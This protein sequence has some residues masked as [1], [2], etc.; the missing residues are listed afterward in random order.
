MA[1][2]A[3]HPAF[4]QAVE[5]IH[6]VVYFAPDAKERYG[7]LGLRGY[8]RGYFASRAGALGT[9]GAEVVTAA[10]HGFAPGMVARAVPEVWSLADREAVLDARLQLAREAVGPAVE[11][12]GQDAQALADSLT[13]ALRELDVAGKV[14]AAAHR[15]VPAPDDA[16]GRLWH[17][18]TVFREYRGDCHVAVLTAAGLGGCAAN[19]LQV[20]T[21]RAEATQREHR[22]WTEQE[23]A[24]AQESLREWGWVGD[25]GTA[26]DLGRV[27]RDRLEDATD[28]AC[29]AG[30]GLTTRARMVTLA[31]PLLDVA[32]AVADSGAVPFPNPTGGQ[33]P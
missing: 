11:A 12:A 6:D 2:T 18:A 14:L 7:A 17:A 33:R 10:F 20:A 31:E 21:G 30:I 4:W 15:S 24:A 23:W 5:T 29:D 16:V 26:T 28:R 1:E 8:W 19:V 9:P 27:A 32:R 22:G 3:R 13:I 25:D